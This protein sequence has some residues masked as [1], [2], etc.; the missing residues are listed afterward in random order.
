M[1]ETQLVHR[2]PGTTGIELTDRGEAL[3]IHATPILHSLRAA[4]ADLAVLQHQRL[5]VGML[6]SLAPRLLRPVLQ[7]TEPIPELVEV[8][9]EDRLAALVADGAVEVAFGEPP[10]RVGPFTVHRIGPD[11]YVLAIPR[12]W[13]LMLDPNRLAYG[14]LERLPLV[15]RGD[16]PTAARTTAQLRARG[17]EPLRGAHA[18]SDTAALALVRAGAATAI[19]PQS[20]IDT[21]DDA[22]TSVPLVGL[23]SPRTICWYFHRDRRLSEDIARIA[24]AAAAAHRTTQESLAT[25]QRNDSRPRD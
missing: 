2:Q 13:C 20:A 3:L 19:V 17:I 1:L 11:P 21:W 22:I 23:I 18:D 25:A 10:S 4:K 6:A 9:D 14:L 5:R 24:S 8:D 12:D 7:A 15:A 16:S